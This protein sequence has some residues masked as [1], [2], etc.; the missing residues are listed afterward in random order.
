[1]IIQRPSEVSLV[2]MSSSCLLS[3]WSRNSFRFSVLRQDSHWCMMHLLLAGLQTIFLIRYLYV[4]S[5][6]ITLTSNATFRWALKKIHRVSQFW[7]SQSTP[8]VSQVTEF[9]EPNITFGC[10]SLKTVYNSCKLWR[11]LQVAKFLFMSSLTDLL[12]R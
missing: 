8:F 10:F 1:M 6:A 4:K 11:L 12:F 9:W 7:A 3:F 5:Q 2:Y